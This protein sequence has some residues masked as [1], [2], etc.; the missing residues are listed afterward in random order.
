VKRIS[1]KTREEAALICQVAASNESHAE[2]YSMVANDL[3]IADGWFPAVESL[4]MA[5]QAWRYTQYM[6]MPDAEAEALLR[7]GW[8]PS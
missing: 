2:S 1:K 5:F 7:T 3:G 4:E 6:E 8:E